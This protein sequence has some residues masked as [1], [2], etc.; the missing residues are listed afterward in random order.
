M[1]SRRTEWDLS[2]NPLSLALKEL[3]AAGSS[4]I[5]LTESNPTRAGF[6]YPQEWLNAFLDTN[7][8]IYDPLS[9]GMLK[10]REAVCSY[11]AGRGVN[12]SAD[13]VVLTASTSEA[14]SFLFRLLMNPEDEV[15]IPAPGY[16]LFSYLA[17]LND[18]KEVNYRLEFDGKRWSLDLDSIERAARKGRVRA[19]VLVSPNNPTGSFV[20]KEEFVRL[21]ALCVKYGMAIISD[22]VFCDYVV[23]DHKADYVSAA[24]NTGALSFAMAGL[25][26]SLALPQ[27]KLGWIVV[28]GPEALVQPALARLE[29]IADTYLSVSTPV[30]NACV[31]WLPEAHRIRDEIMARV[32]ENLKALKEAVRASSDVELL[33][34]QG[35]WYALLRLPMDIPEDEWVLRLLKEKHVYVHPGFY[36]DFEE[37]GVVVVS[38]LPV[39]ATFEAGLAAL[40]AV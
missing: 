24:S 37:E 23:D 30:Q 33:P 14:Y 31:Q 4:F 18:V 9:N 6:H 7:N 20:R 12:V 36:F 34:V 17:G 11:Y 10:A 26:K 5:D 8:F 1:F 16:P 22:E 13:R 21:N 29:V 2:E 19:I 40:L 35:G 38:L 32:G 39:P 28:N 3:N 15:L 27:M 25:S